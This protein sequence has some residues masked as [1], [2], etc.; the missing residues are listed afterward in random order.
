MTLA[1]IIGWA[2][3]ALGGASDG[4]TCKA[5]GQLVRL[6]GLSEAS[7]LAVSR[8]SKGRL[9][10][11]NDSGAPVLI[12]FDA[13]GRINGKVAVT[14][15]R[16]EDW[17]ALTSGPC[18]SGSCLYVGD[19]GD[20]NGKRATITVY[21]MPEPGSA[22]GSVKAEAFQASYPDGGHDAESLL[23]APD[24]T[25][26]VVTKGDTGPV[27]V[28]RFPRELQTGSV[29]RLERVGKPL[30]EK[31]SQ[32]QRI[33]DAA[34][35]NDGKLVVLRT[36]EGVTI[37]DAGGFMRGEFRALGTVNLASLGEPQGEGIAF[38]GNSTMYVV[39]EGGGKK[40][41]GTL[42]ALTCTF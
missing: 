16:V 23:I 13:S 22:G 39:G 42:G 35:S 29:M 7:G 41:P 20:N 1:V 26:L 34:M 12:S 15:A 18:A 9:W 37:Y 17:E 28:Y 11:H 24:G 8:T 6:E 4:L 19:I 10:S 21:R 14:G 30:F 25:L 40:A 27:A 3:L 36:K 5:S 38:G 32:R 33:T 2:A 31:P